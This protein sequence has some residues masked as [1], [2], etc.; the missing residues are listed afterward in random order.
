MSTQRTK[1]SVPTWDLSDRMA[2]ALKVAGLSVQDMADFLGVSRNT[3]GNYTHGR[4]KPDKRTLMLWAMGTGVPQG[5]LET[6][7]DT[8]E[9]GGGPSPH[10]HRYSVGRHPVAA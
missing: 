9:D 10:T 5:W 8:G 3:V 7:E 1:T 4:T 6:G 2:K